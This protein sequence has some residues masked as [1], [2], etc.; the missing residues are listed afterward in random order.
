MP[1]HERHPKGGNAFKYG[2]RSDIRQDRVEHEEIHADGRRDEV[3]RASKTYSKD[4]AKIIV[5]E[6]DSDVREITTASLVKLGYEVIDGDGGSG[7]LEQSEDIHQS[8]DLL[9]SDV[10][11]PNGTNGVDI[12]SQLKEKCRNLKVPLMTGYADQDILVPT[13]SDR[14]FELLK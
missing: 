9:L 4:P 8:V 6:D 12:T 3:G 13:V 2:A 7:V 11:L 10:V 1:H 14:R 5:I